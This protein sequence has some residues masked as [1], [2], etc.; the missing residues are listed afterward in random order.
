MKS[1][2][3]HSRPAQLTV[4]AAVYYRCL[5]RCHALLLS[6]TS[7]ARSRVDLELPHRVYPTREYLD[8]C[9]LIT[10]SYRRP[11]VFLS[12]RKPLLLLLAVLST[13]VLFFVS[14]CIVT[15]VNILCRHP[16]HFMLG[17]ECSFVRVDLSL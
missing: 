3:F 4:V 2:E 11:L 1:S 13:A 6:F 15:S 12:D 17:L 5:S 16:C 14:L 7:S 9:L 10:S 8:L